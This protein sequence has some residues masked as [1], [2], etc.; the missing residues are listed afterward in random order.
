MSMRRKAAILQVSDSYENGKIRVFMSYYH[1]LVT[2]LTNAGKRGK[3]VDS[4]SLS[5]K[6]RENFNSLLEYVDR[7]D[8]QTT[9]VD[10]LE[11][12]PLFLEELSFNENTKR[13]VDVIP[14][15]VKPIKVQNAKM[16]LQSD[17]KGF[18][19]RDLTDV[20]E[21]SA[22]EASRTDAS[23]AYKFFQ[24]NI[25]DLQNMS[26]KSVLMAMNKNR[27]NYKSYYALD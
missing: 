18:Q 21:A 9:Y 16:Y 5:I 2:D 25:A 13:G 8:S 4:F 14:G 1:L 11:E 24:Q 22:Y 3:T 6:K 20:N 19:M 15:G 10:A 12:V 23:K 27:I 17:P 7:I 26:F